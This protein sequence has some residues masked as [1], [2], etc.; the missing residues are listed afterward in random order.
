MFEK[1]N[2]FKTKEIKNLIIEREYTPRSITAVVK[3]SSLGLNISVSSINKMR[4]TIKQDQIMSYSQYF[5]SFSNALNISPGAKVRWDLIL[6][7]RRY[8]EYRE[9]LKKELR[10]SQNLVTSYYS[11]IF[12]LR[13]SVYEISA[14]SKIAQVLLKPLHT[15]TAL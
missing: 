2:N 5:A 3:N 13:K 4:E 10:I 8:F 14:K 9:Y 15:I 7:S 11:D 12:A 6:D 1:I